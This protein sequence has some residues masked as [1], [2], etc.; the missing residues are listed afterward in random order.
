MT[1]YDS[2][3]PLNEDV[4]EQVFSII[5]DQAYP[6]LR[7]L[8]LTN[9]RFHVL[10]RPFLYRYIG[11][12]VGTKAFIDEVGSW[13]ADSAN[14][15]VLKAIR[16]ISIYGNEYGIEDQE[17][18][19]H[20][21]S[22]PLK[23][24]DRNDSTNALTSCLKERQP[25][26]R[27]GQRD[28][29]AKWAMLA[30][31]V[32]NTTQLQTVCY[33]CPG[34]PIPLVLVRAIHQYPTLVRLDLPAWARVP[35][36]LSHDDPA[37]LEL[38]GSPSLRSI[39]ARIWNPSYS[40][41]DLR[42]PALWRL[43]GSSPNLRTV[44]LH[45]SFGGCVATWD[46][47]TDIRNWEQLASHF[48]RSAVH[49]DDSGTVI[50]NLR[51]T[52]TD[53]S[54]IE[55]RMLSNIVNLDCHSLPLE[56]LPSFMALAHLTLR[57]IYEWNAGLQLETLLAHHGSSLRALALHDFEG[58]DILNPRPALSQ[59]QLL[60]IKNGCPHL[61]ELSL[62]LDFPEEPIPVL[63]IKGQRKFSDMIFR[64]K[65]F[66]PPSKEVLSK[67]LSTDTHQKV[68]D[69]IS[70]FPCLRRLQLNFNLR[71]ASYNRLSSSDFNGKGLPLADEAFVRRVWNAVDLPTLQELRVAQ[72][73]SERPGGRGYPAGWVIWE[74]SVQ[75]WFRATRSERDDEPNEIVVSSF[76]GIPN[77]TEDVWRDW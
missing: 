43:I 52:G 72:G 73:E 21:P 44:V 33:G 8:L 25:P 27:L 61:N 2:L 59:E 53:L 34:H 17:L 14:S 29:D 23:I 11:I 48:Q 32:S 12:D 42:L 62:D 40:P 24:I 20:Y 39:R 68:Y 31:L 47:P 30:K 75:R 5:C 65:K 37:E 66:S 70:E 26:M 69:T 28:L 67:L 77:F 74:Q 45:I 35:F 58:V 15:A 57:S 19:A 56:R 36:N 13:L 1:A 76:S 41:S 54:R 9:R 7:A 63:D 71:I 4:L 64:R 18:N 10:V 3:L 6:T 51:V 50:K 16:H 22:R 55:D 49:S 46:S 60:K 38:L